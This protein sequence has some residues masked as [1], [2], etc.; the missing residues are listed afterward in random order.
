[1][2]LFCNIDFS[3]IVENPVIWAYF[4]ENVELTK[5]SSFSK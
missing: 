4:E 1:M 2:T 5:P 3:E